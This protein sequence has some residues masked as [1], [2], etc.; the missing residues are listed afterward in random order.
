MSF[1]SHGQ[2]FYGICLGFP[3]LYRNIQFVGAGD[4]VFV[5]EKFIYLSPD[6]ENLAFFFHIYCMPI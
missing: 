2:L 4:G 6:S 3:H 1:Q 5:S